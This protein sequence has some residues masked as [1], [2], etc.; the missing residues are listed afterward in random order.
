MAL[1]EAMAAGVPVVAARVGG[2]P[3]IIGD[4][5]AARLV[6]GHDPLAWAQALEGVLT[7]R[8]AT[9]EMI[10]RAHALVAERFSIDAMHTRYGELYHTVIA[11]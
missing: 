2:I 9:E 6:E 8:A 11:T 3:E 1:L 10:T 4:S 7:D 5:G